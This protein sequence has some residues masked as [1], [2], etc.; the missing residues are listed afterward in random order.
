MVIAQE[1]NGLTKEGVTEIAI[2]TGRLRQKREKCHKIRY[3]SDRLG[4]IWAKFEVGSYLRS[5]VSYKVT[6]MLH[7]INLT[8]L[9]TYKSLK[10]FTEEKKIWR[11]T[12]FRKKLTKRRY[13]LCLKKTKNKISMQDLEDFICFQNL[14]C[15]NT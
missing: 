4:V 8:Y 14:F 10:E 9:S 7:S 5:C 11:V 15:F 6:F 12:N 13:F 1:C 3:V 2:N